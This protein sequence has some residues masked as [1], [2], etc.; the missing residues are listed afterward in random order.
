VRVFIRGFTTRVFFALMHARLRCTRAA[1][2]TLH[3]AC[4][5]LRLTSFPLVESRVVFAR[6]ALFMHFAT[7]TTSAGFSSHH[8]IAL[9]PSPAALFRFPRRRICGDS[10]FAARFS[11]QRQWKPGNTASSLTKAAEKEARERSPFELY[12][13]PA[14]S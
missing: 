2:S 5:S 7:F 14:R 3:R 8:V 4:R 12:Q 10:R 11:A 1:S 9:H 6:C 13:N